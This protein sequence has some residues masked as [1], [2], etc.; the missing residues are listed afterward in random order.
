MYCFGFAEAMMETGYEPMAPPRVLSIRVNIP[1]QFTIRGRPFR[2]GC[3]PHNVPQGLHSFLH[4]VM[5]TLL[6]LPATPSFL[7]FPLQH[8]ASLAHYTIVSAL[9]QTLFTSSSNGV[10]LTP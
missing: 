1:H 5:Q 4:S 9:A 7:K 6:I 10:F 8:P 3:Y 2:K